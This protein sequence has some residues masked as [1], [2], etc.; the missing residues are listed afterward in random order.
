MTADDIDGIED[1]CA[2][3]CDDGTVTTRLSRMALDEGLVMVDHPCWEWEDPFD[4][5][6]YVEYEEEQL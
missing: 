3:H 2:G 6:G 5:V 1:E 4:L